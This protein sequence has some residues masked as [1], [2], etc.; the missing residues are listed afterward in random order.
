MSKPLIV[1]LIYV[2]F[3]VPVV[4]L[5]LTWR[6][7][8]KRRGSSL[9]IIATMVFSAS[10]VCALALLFRAPGIPGDYSVGR[11]AIIDANLIAT[12]IGIVLGL[13]GRQAR[14]PL[15]TSGVLVLVLWLYLSTVSAVV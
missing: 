3:A 14:R 5:V 2:L 8:A 10:Y 15:L 11:A 9:A 1:A 6:A 13:A 7:L 4:A 12:V